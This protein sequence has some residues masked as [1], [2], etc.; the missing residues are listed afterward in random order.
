[1]L[2][3]LSCRQ[4]RGRPASEFRRRGYVIKVLPVITKKNPHEEH[5]LVGR[6]T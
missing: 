5:H 3:L 2:L 1:M 6:T 4:K